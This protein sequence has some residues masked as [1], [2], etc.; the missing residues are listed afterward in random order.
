MLEMCQ[1]GGYSPRE[2]VYHAK[3]HYRSKIDT[4]QT[5]VL[6]HNSISLKPANTLACSR[7]QG[8]SKHSTKGLSILLDTIMEVQQASNKKNTPPQEFNVKY[9]IINPQGSPKGDKR[10][11]SSNSLTILLSMRASKYSSQRASPSSNKLNQGMSIII[12]QKHH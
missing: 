4:S 3:Y 8:N 7:E 1:G 12:I 2:V 11:H 5:R 6:H 10:E 9:L